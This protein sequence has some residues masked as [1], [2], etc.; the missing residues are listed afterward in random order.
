MFIL[1]A[2]D[3]LQAYV[4]TYDASNR[5]AMEEEID[6]YKRQAPMWKALPARIS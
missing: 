2:L 5:L 4:S 3:Q 6:V 1:V